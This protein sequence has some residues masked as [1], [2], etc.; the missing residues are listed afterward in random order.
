MPVR[1]VYASLYFIGIFL[2]GRGIHEQSLP[3]MTYMAFGVAI[4]CGAACIQLSE[5]K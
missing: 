3:P 5:K 4:I 1:W 2:L